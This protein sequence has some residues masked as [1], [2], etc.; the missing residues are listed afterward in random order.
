MDWNL[1]RLVTTSAQF[2]KLQHGI[3]PELQKD[4]VSRL[5]VH[6]G[7]SRAGRLQTRVAQVGKPF[8]RVHVLPWDR[9]GGSESSV[10]LRCGDVLRGRQHKPLY[11]DGTYFAD[12]IRVAD[13]LIVLPLYAMILAAAWGWTPPEMSPTHASTDRAARVTVRGSKFYQTRQLSRRPRVSCPE[14]SGV[15]QPHRCLL[16]SAAGVLCAVWNSL[17]HSLF[18]NTENTGDPWATS[19]SDPW[20]LYN[21]IPKSEV[22]DS[23]IVSPST[24]TPAPARAGKGRGKQKK[25]LRFGPPGASSTGDTK[26]ETQRTPSTCTWMTTPQRQGLTLAGAA[27]LSDPDGNAPA[28]L[29]AEGVKENATG[30]AFVDRFRLPELA[31]VRSTGCLALLLPGHFGYD[32]ASMCITESATNKLSLVCEDPVRKSRDVH[33]LTLLNLGAKSWTAREAKVDATLVAPSLAELVL[34]AEKSYFPEPAWLELKSRP[35]QQMMKLFE[36]CVT[37]QEFRTLQFGKFSQASSD[38]WQ[39]VMRAPLQAK[40]VLLQKSGLVNSLLLHELIRDG[41]RTYTEPL[42]GEQFPRTPEGLERAREL[43]RQALRNGASLLGLAVT[44]GGL[45]VRVKAGLQHVRKLVAKEDPRY[46]DRNIALIPKRWWIAKNWPKGLDHGVVAKTCFE[47]IA[48]NVIPLAP[49]ATGD[50]VSW[51]LASV[52][53]STQDNF[54]LASG[55]IL[56]EPEQTVSWDAVPAQNRGTR[57]KSQR[58]A[59][60]PSSAQPA[61]SGSGTG[62]APSAIP[63][64][65]EARVVALETGLK[66]QQSDLQKLGS[67]VDIGFSKQEASMTEIL[68]LL[69]SNQA[70]SVTP[71]SKRSLAD[72]DE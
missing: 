19:S 20:Q 18:G 41:E 43:Y 30:V 52:D 54:R 49:R 63:G 39:L 44:R 40:E 66:K 31:A 65:L 36:A 29:A 71:R 42:R 68:T 8:Q 10:Q 26:G 70:G 3:K 6:G 24:G 69:K 59:R 53:T 67:K 1:W 7:H 25:S 61:S 50:T 37:A 13:V 55:V 56:I 38:Y 17:M 21:S 11:G 45:A 27:Q 15:S 46:N 12:S 2:A 14:I 58:D 33:K 57:S 64:T 9:S 22:A 4:M 28:I 34:D 23:A 16:Q 47:A 72:T 48:W 60:P 51:R 5:E 35:R 62:S 32:W